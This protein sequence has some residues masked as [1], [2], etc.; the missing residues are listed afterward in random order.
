MAGV[1]GGDCGRLILKRSGDLASWLGFNR[2]PDYERAVWLGHAFGFLISVLILFY[3]ILTVVVFFELLRAS[4]RVEPYSK[5]ADESI[6]NIGLVFAALVGAPFLVWRTVSA[7][8]QVKIAEI[9]EFNDRL[10]SAN[11]SLF[12]RR[13]KTTRVNHNGIDSVIREIEDDFVQRSAGIDQLLGFVD[14]RAELAPRI[15]RVLA[16]YIRGNFP[17]V[18]LE[19]T[20]GIS[21][22]VTPRGDLQEAVDAIGRVLEVAQE[23]DNGHWRLNLSRCNFDGVRFDAGNFRAV[24]FNESR[25]EGAR[26][27]SAS[28]HGALL[29]GCLLSHS[30]F[31]KCDLTGAKL[32]RVILNRPS[33]APG[34]FFTPFP[35]TI[36]KG[37]SFIGADISSV[38]V[39]GSREEI[40]ETFGTKDTILSGDL[41][42]LMPDANDHSRAST[43][44]STGRADLSEDERDIVDRVERTG[45]INWSPWNSSD[46]AT[47]HLLHNF[48]SRL[49]LLRFPYW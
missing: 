19:N 1:H 36:L 39:L 14:E 49:D 8:R 22:A 9:S 2:K 38:S 7:S 31:I 15:V 10:V 30:E 25:F 43:I 11:E 37:V 41:K 48:Y 13:E 46:L 34:G 47:T 27:R 29:Q 17:A 40:L 24:N 4:L 6:R 33:I 26:L 28:F 18:D 20:D 44:I 21:R 42:F 23:V 16:A 5:D 12:A 45:F 3:L 32:D 35:G